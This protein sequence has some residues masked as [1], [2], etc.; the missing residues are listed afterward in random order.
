MKASQVAAN[1]HRA[2]ALIDD[3]A[4][5]L[6]E[7][8]RCAERMTRNHAEPAFVS[9]RAMV[10]RAAS[11]LAPPATQVQPGPHTTPVDKSRK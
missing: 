8:L 9:A 3:L 1:P 2:A 6:E 7:L 10:E 11:P 4:D 5:A